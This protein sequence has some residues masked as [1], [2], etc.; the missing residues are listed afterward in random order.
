MGL[1]FCFVYLN[2]CWVWCDLFVL[3]GYSL[4]CCFCLR[5]LRLC[6]WFSCLLFVFC[7]F[8]C[9]IWLWCYCLFVILLGYGL[10]GLLD[11]AFVCWMFCF[12]L[13]LDVLCLDNSVV[14]DL[15]DFV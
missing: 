3:V 2:A 7:L 12:A 6:L 1:T 10:F 14:A 9:L 8:G 5:W 13:C 15:Y 11:L 4:V